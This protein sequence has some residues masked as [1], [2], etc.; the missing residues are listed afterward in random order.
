MSP[1]LQVLVIFILFAGIDLPVY[2]ILTRNFYQG[3]YDRINKG[4][5]V[6]TG[7]AYVSAILVYLLLATGLYVFVIQ[8]E[9]SK[10]SSTAILFM[11]GMF[12]GLLT[13]GASDLIN[14]A[15]VSHFGVRETLIDLTWATLF[16]GFLSV[17]CFHVTR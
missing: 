2:T 5:T 14:L 8:P 17:I 7:R 6:P 13:Y 1:F 16:C 11:K 12:F 4:Q 9:I 10:Q 15:T 3:M